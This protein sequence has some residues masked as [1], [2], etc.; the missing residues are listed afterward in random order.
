MEERGHDRLLLV[1]PAMTRPDG[2]PA[3]PVQQ[4][5]LGHDDEAPSAFMSPGMSLRDWFAGMAAQGILND[6]TMQLAK[7]EAVAAWAYEEADALL[8]EREKQT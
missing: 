7:A 6:H 1:R 5:S 8:R 2:G 3:F 4:V